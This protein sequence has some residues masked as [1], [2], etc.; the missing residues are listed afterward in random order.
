MV[1]A[2]S[3]VEAE[4]ICMETYREE[5]RKF[6]R[7]MYQSKMKVNEQFGRKMNEG[8]NGNRELFWK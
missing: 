8:V 5:K 7:C 6:K 1:L 2:A 3:D 4:E